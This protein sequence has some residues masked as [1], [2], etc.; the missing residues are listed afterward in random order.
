[1]T[2]LNNVIKLFD[3]IKLY[4][5]IKPNDKKTSYYLDS[6]I[7]VMAVFLLLVI[8]VPVTSLAI[9]EPFDF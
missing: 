4:D 1:V 5:V 9:L 6:V 2:K 7:G 3:R 8:F